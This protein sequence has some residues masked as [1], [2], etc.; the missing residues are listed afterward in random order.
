MMEVKEVEFMGDTLLGAKIDSKIYVG[1]TWICQGLGFDKNQTDT[2][3][4]KIQND[5]VLSKGASKIPLNIANAGNPNILCLDITYLPLWLAKINA[6]IVKP[7]IK[8]KL[9]EYQLRAK[10]VLAEA[11]VTQYNPQ[12]NHSIPQIPQT[13]QEALRLLADSMDTVATNA[14]K[15][16]A[17]DRFMDANGSQNVS[18]VAKALGTGRDRLFRFLRSRGI[19]MRNNEPYQQYI[20]SGY[21]EVIETVSHGFVNARTMVT[22][23]GI[24]FIERLLYPKIETMEVKLIHR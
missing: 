12:V 24:G 14:P 22:P 7:E 8:G 16:K 18:Q 1:I 2:Q 19:L 20:T 13:F 21:F 9:V 15:V 6:N 4:K 11:F 3:I 5:L 23:K 10:D 17:F